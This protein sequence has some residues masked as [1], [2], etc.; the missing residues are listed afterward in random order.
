MKT[1]KPTNPGKF[2]GHVGDARTARGVPVLV[3]DRSPDWEVCFSANLSIVGILLLRQV[4]RRLAQIGGVEEQA[5]RLEHLS[6]YC[7]AML[8]ASIIIY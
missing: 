8:C 3:S 2:T 4:W 7:E 6:S 5:V 1:T